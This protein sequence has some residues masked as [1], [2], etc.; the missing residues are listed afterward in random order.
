MSDPELVGLS[1]IAT[2]LR[3]AR[4]TVDTWRHRGQMPPP[5][6]VVSGRPAWRWQTIR[7]WAERTGRIK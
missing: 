2:R 1:D 6:F 3:V 7:R 5:D 4:A